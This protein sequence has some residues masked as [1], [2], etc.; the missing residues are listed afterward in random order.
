[1]LKEYTPLDGSATTPLDDPD[2]TILFDVSNTV[3]G[4][5]GCNTYA[6]TFVSDG[7]DLDI[8]IGSVTR[9]LC[10]QPVMDQEQMFLQLL[11]EVQEYSVTADGSKLEML[12]ERTIN[13]Q[14]EDVI[15]MAFHAE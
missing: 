12:A 6:G 1:M 10:D 2:S 13:D 11:D 3:S 9:L 15:I 7:T 5:G 14:Q 4:S 8:E